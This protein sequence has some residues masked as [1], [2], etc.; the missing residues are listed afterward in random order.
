MVT[1]IDL[2]AGAGRGIGR[3]IALFLAASGRRV[4][5][6]DLNPDR[7]HQTVVEIR[8]QEGQARAYPADIAKK[9]AVQVIANQLEDDGYRVAAVYNCARVTPANALLDMDE[10]EWRRTLDVNLTGAFV[11]TQVFG[12]VMRASGQAGL[13]CHILRESEAAPAASAAYNAARAGLQAMVA[14]AAAEFAALPIRVSIRH[15]QANTPA[16]SVLAD[17]Q[18]GA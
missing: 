3:E 8:A 13:I 4:A 1:D 17:P 18:S 11:L 15:A 10:W 7:A 6:N 5:V 12:R 2:V 14:S 9:V 16:K